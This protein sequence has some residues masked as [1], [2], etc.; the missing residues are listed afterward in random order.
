VTWLV[1]STHGVTRCE[2]PQDVVFA[3]ADHIVNTGLEF[4]QIVRIPAKSEDE[5]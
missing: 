2:T 4:V 3:K 1:M 5:R